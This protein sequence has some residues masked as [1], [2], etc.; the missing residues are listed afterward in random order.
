MAGVA[1]ARGLCATESN[2]GWPREPKKCPT[3]LRAEPRSAGS[4]LAGAD[5][6]EERSHMVRSDHPLHTVTHFPSKEAT[7]S[8]CPIVAILRMG[9]HGVCGTGC[10]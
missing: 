1:R 7:A 4:M 6:E 8:H 9:G 10:W 2:V 3:D 5:W